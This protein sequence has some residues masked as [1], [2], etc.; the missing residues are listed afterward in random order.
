M[1]GGSRLRVGVLYG[2]R[3]GEHEV[4]VVSASSVVRH[5]DSDRYDVVPLY[6]DREGR[7]LI[8]GAPPTALTAAEAAGPV[9]AAGRARGWIRDRQQAWSRH[10][11]S[12][13][14]RTLR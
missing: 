14:A 4:S 11:L 2:G 6:I 1:T 12:H 3:S 8:G 10:R 13:P 5:L 7:W 9:L